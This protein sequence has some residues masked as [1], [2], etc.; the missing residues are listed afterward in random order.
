MVLVPDSS[1]LPQLFPMEAAIP[2][3]VEPVTLSQ[4]RDELGDLE[5]AVWLQVHFE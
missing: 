1:S 2:M 3:L 5:K 4:V